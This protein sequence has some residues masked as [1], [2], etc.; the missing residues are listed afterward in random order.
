VEEKPHCGERQSWSSGNVLARLVDPAPQRVLVLQCAPLGRDQPEHDLLARGHE[1][2]R[3][4]GARAGVV[5]LE[6]EPV[7]IQAGEQRLGDEV[8]AALGR[9]R[10]LEVAAAHVRGHPHA[11]RSTCD[12]GVDLPDE[13]LVLVIGV[14]STGG[15]HLALVRFV[16]VREARVV[17][18]EVGTAELSQSP[19]RPNALLWPRWARILVR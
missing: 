16:E 15:D 10:G 19:D 7:D 5:E 14:L 1:P 4:K 3:G 6:E 8:V 13:P 17:E 11:L 18:L 12:R 9:P 2:Q